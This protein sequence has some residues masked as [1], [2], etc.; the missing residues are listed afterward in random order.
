MSSAAV[1]I[2]TLKVK[3]A[4][5]IESGRIVST[6]SIPFTLGC[7]NILGNDGLLVILLLFDC[8]YYSDS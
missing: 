4:G 6:E 3:K 8:P 5:K 7:L 2:S 1:V